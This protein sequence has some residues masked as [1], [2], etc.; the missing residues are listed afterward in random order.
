MVYIIF[1]VAIPGILSAGIFAFTCYALVFLSSPEQKGGAGRGHLRTGPRR[2]ILLR[3]GRPVG[4]R[5][6]D[7]PAHDGGEP[8]V[9]ARVHEKLRLAVNPDR[10]HFFENQTEAAI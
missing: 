5:Q 10:V 8:T 2:H 6:D 4:L 9:T 7:D 3:R 1:P